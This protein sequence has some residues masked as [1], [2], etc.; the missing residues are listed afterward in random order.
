MPVEP[1]LGWVGEV[2]AEF[3]EARAEVGIKDIEVVDGHR[4]VGLV[5][6]EVDRL[7]VGVLPR[8]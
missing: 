3:D 7:A 4:P 6:A 2:A 8:W 1:H 5:E